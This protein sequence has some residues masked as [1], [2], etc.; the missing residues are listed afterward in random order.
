VNVG[1]WLRLHAVRACI[2]TS[3]VLKIV[4]FILFDL[5]FSSLIISF[6]L[7]SFICGN[8]AQVI[9]AEAMNWP[10]QSGWLNARRDAFTI[11]GLTEGYIKRS[12]L[13]SFW[14]LNRAGHSVSLL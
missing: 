14:W 9:W 2:L 11:D 10:G 3:S 5:F 12:G 6:L 13:F 8:S 1:N 7:I 4:H